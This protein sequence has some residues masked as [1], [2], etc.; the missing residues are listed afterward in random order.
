MPDYF[1]SVQWA[2]PENK[3]AACAVMLRRC[4]VEAL[5]DQWR[6]CSADRGVSS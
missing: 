5:R 2:R 3:S 6:P 4:A 1:F